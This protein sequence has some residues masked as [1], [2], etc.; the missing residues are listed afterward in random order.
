MLTKKVRKYVLIPSLGLTPFIV[1]FIAIWVTSRIDMALI[2]SMLFAVIA[3]FSLSIWSNTKIGVVFLASFIPL[4]ITF[5]FWKFSHDKI[6]IPIIYY[7][8]PD[9]LMIVMIMLIRASKVFLSIHFFRHESIN[10]KIFVNQF[11]EGAVI[12]QYLLTFHVFLT[13]TYRQLA[14][15]QL[16]SEDYDIFVFTILPVVAI[17][18][19]I[20]YEYVKNFKVIKKLNKEEWLPIVNDRG[21]VKGKIAKSIS[22]KMKNKFLHPIVRVALVCKGKVYLQPRRHDDEFDPDTFDY[23]FEKYMLFTHEINVAARNSIFNV[24]GKEL[25]T[26]FL[27]KYT[28]E[29]EETKRL[30]FLFISRLKDEQDIEDVSDKL[31]GKFW[32]M[33]QI[34]DDFGDSSKFSECFQLEYEYLKN[35]V[36]L[37]DQIDNNMTFSS[38][39]NIHPVV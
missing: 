8:L 32:S 10:L 4:L 20:V 37:A 21:E 16:V 2:L 28:F 29:N 12:I 6:Q 23:P 35:T 24:I 7:T 11:F 25:P 27:L 30:I 1:Y 19:L 13:F 3:S 22:L 31:S 5:V 17:L 9:I 38:S 26:H 36:L 33:K 39:S 14:F 34:E 18:L 15:N